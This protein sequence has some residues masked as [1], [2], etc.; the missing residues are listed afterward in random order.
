[1]VGDGWWGGAEGPQRPAKD[2]DSETTADE[3][4]CGSQK[5]GGTVPLPFSRSQRGASAQTRRAQ[6]WPGQANR[7]GPAKREGPRS[8]SG[9][10]NPEPVAAK[11]PRAR[12]IH[13]SLH[14]WGEL[15]RCYSQGLTTLLTT[16]DQALRTSGPATSAATIN[17]MV[18]TESQTI[19]IVRCSRRRVRVYRKATSAPI[20]SPPTCACHAMPETKNP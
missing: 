2:Q 4:R 18:I 1:M 11:T 19:W 10:S 20:A 5:S 15:H 6:G 17:R 7:E 13:R 12:V 8:A 9:D 14:N 16:L 3:P